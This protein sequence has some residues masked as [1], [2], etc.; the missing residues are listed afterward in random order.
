MILFGRNRNVKGKRVLVDYAL[1]T[2]KEA[3]DLGIPYFPWREAPATGSVVDKVP[4]ESYMRS[5]LYVRDDNGWVSPVVDGVNWLPSGRVQVCFV[6]GRRYASHRTFGYGSEVMTSRFDWSFKEARRER[7][8]RVVAIY[9][10]ML[11]Q[12]H[13]LTREDWDLLGKIYRSD[14]KN[15]TATVRTLFKSKGVKQMVREELKSVLVK[16]NVTADFVM[17]E[18]VD[19][20]T[21]SKDVNQFAVAKA[22]VDKFAD[23]L[24]MKP[25]RVEIQATRLSMG[26]LDHLLG[27]REEVLEVTEQELEDEEVIDYGDE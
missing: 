10:E 16:S 11:I 1:F 15:P 3:D 23:M 2:V 12:R 21:K 4:T 27:G 14:E 17:E 5:W 8:K 7:T 24:D 22:I 26:D 18:Y 19:I 9:V 6:F 25:D 20:L 13:T